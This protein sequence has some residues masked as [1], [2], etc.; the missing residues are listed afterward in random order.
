MDKLSFYINYIVSL[1]ESIGPAGGFLLIMLESVLPP[2]PLGVIVGFNMI[3]FG[4]FFGF[5]LSYIATIC[6]CI[7]SFILFR[8]FFK[9]KFINKFSK[10]NRESINKW[11]DKLSNIKMPTLALLVALPVTPSFA[12]NIAA[13]LSDMSLRKFFI[14]IC[15]GKPAM[16]FFYGYIA[17]SVM[18]SLKDPMNI[19]RVIALMIGVYIISKIIEKVVK[20]DE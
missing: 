19:V 4:K 12:V 17:V 1:F 15:I 20:V 7:L 5:I 3:S 18:E 9:G 11:K 8:Y 6:G 2:L 14:S 10:K 13:G 16:L